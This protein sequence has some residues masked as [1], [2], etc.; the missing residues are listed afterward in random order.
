MATELRRL[1]PLAAK[2]ALSDSDFLVPGKHPIHQLLDQLQEAAVGW[3]AR[4]GRAGQACHRL[5]T[6]AVGDALALQDTAQPAPALAK[7]N[8]RI[9]TAIQRDDARARRM[10]PQRR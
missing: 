8:E 2:M 3:Q 9:S 4:L 5:V 6:G 1:K 7:L 10:G